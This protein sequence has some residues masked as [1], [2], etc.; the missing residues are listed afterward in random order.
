LA[1]N[2]ADAGQTAN[3]TRSGETGFLY[4]E[5]KTTGYARGSK[6]AEADDEKKLP[7]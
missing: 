2:P 3:P 7:L 4:C 6:K 5:T 1:E